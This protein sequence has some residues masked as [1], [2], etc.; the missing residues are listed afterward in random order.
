MAGADLVTIPAACRDYLGISDETG[1]TLARTGRFPGEAAIR[2]GSQWRVSLPKLLRYL[3]G[4][5]VDRQ[6]ALDEQAS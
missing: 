5:D 6:L 1:Y 3:H 2:I 4:D